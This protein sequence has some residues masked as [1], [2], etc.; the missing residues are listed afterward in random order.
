MPVK[1]LLVNAVYSEVPIETHHPALGFG[2][3]ASTLRKEFRDRIVFKVINSYL[4]ENIKEFQPDII[5]ITSVTKNFNVAKEY[6]KIAKQA[7]I[8]VI[9]GG[10]HI[11]FMPQTI[12]SDMTIGIDGEGEAT[13]V[14]LMAL[15]LNK[16]K[17]N[18][19]DLYGVKGIMFWDKGELIKTEPRELIK[20]LDTI[21]YPARD[22]LTIHSQAH[23]L[24]S[25]GCPYN[26]AFCSTSSYTRHYTRY[27][28]A[29]YVAEEIAQIYDNY[30]I[31]HLTIYDDM[32]TINTN[33]VA[34]IQ[35]LLSGRNLIG[36]FGISVN[37][38]AD[39]ITDALAEILRSMNVKV[40]ALGTESGCQKTLDY[41]KS[42]GLT[43][44]N[45]ANAVRILKK[46]HIIPYCSFVIGS[47]D[48]SYA[49]MMQTI[50]FIKENNIYYYD[51]SI[52]VPF[53]GTKIWDYALSVGEVS[54]DM[55]WDRLN[56]YIKPY[57]VN[58]SKHLSIDDMVNIRA[59][60]EIRK[61]S[62]LYFINA[63]LA[64]RHPIKYS[65]KV[66]ERIRR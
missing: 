37:I 32:F 24:S 18:K 50:K 35:K 25:R 27:A 6:A 31:S 54:E 42:G 14:E 19:A 39:F 65:K 36:K 44:E 30:K 29:E 53:P 26:C 7:G 15:Y 16:G 58:L 57:S 59:K 17:F 64:V 41:L 48:E 60:M 13:I 21:P 47:P 28:G 51:I 66:L 1:F 46:H 3:V 34:Q 12:T 10:V 40:V 52:L 33:R 38:R 61:K 55:D 5:G 43:I 49:D 23:M 62:Y 2:Y 11:T 22:L 20:D 8:P 4:T 56:F 63:C 9:I 45:N